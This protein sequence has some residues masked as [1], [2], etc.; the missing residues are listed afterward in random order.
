MRIFLGFQAKLSPFG[1][2]FGDLGPK[3][4]SIH[5]EV[6]TKYPRFRGYFEEN[7]LF[8]AIFGLKSWILGLKSRKI[9]D[10]E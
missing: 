2:N 8:R 9:G 10:F 4:I 5:D 3:I 7:E 1:L 6:S